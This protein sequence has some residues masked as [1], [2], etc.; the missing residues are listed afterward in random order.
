MRDLVSPSESVPAN[1]GIA[2]VE[3]LS[4]SERMLTVNEVRW[5]AVPLRGFSTLLYYVI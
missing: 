4:R 2:E 3:E 5:M 1:E